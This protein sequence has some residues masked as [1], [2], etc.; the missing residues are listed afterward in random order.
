MPSSPLNPPPPTAADRDAARA[1][2]DGAQVRPAVG[3]VPPGP[4]PADLQGIHGRS[5]AILVADG[6]DGERAKELQR[7]LCAHGAM[8]RF[9]GL[10]PGDVH[11]ATGESLAPETWLEVAPSGGWDAAV[12][13]TGADAAVSLARSGL[14]AAFVRDQHRHGKPILLCRAALPV[15]AAARLPET[16]PSGVADPNLMI[17]DDD[18]ALSRF[19]VGLTHSRRFVSP[20]RPLP[21]PGK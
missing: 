19:V 21:N 3:V 10:L 4:V 16:L 1:A 5:V 20:A 8:A 14:V 18:A 13:P 7:A 6:V 17:G 2:D 9:V 15:L 11:S 12:I